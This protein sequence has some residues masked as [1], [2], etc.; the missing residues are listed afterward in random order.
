M[1]LSQGLLIKCR[2]LFGMFT[3]AMI[4]LCRERLWLVNNPKSF[5]FFVDN[6][7]RSV[8]SFCGLST[9]RPDLVLMGVRAVRLFA[10]LTELG[11]CFSDSGADEFTK[12]S[13]GWP[14]KRGTLVLGSWENHLELRWYVLHFSWK[15]VHI[16]L[17]V[18]TIFVILQLAPFPFTIWT[19]RA[20]S[21]TSGG[22]K[23]LL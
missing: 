17:P 18:G 23:F 12:E 16:D 19:K 15:P 20:L 3:L 2:I 8:P 13:Q 14:F 10:N 21:S 7:I 6:A 1:G 9:W 4:W 22:C 5:F 11:S